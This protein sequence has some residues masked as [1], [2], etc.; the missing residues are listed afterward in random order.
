MEHGAPLQAV[1]NILQ[2]GREKLSISGLLRFCRKIVAQFLSMEVLAAIT[3]HE[4]T[5][6]QVTPSAKNQTVSESLNHFRQSVGAAR[7]DDHTVVASR[8]A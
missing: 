6:F 8:A 2:M 3:L 4:P 7:D 1:F 5:V